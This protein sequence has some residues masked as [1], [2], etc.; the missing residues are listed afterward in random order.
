MADGTAPRW[1]CSFYAKSQE[2]VDTLI[3]GPGGVSICDE[4]VELAY[5][6]VQERKRARGTDPGEPAPR[7]SSSSSS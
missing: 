3:A 7:S 6:T 4:C 5:E 2:Q 1:R